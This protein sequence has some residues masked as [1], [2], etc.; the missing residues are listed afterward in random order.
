MKQLGLFANTAPEPPP[1]VEADRRLVERLPASILL[2]PSSW[3]F[4]DWEGI[5]YPTGMSREDLIERGLERIARYPLFRTVGIDRSHYAPLDEAT[6]QRY[7]SEL[8]AG[9]PCVIK[10]W[11]AITTLIDTR[12]HGQNPAF[13]DT[14]ACEKNVLLPLSRFFYEHTGPLVF[15]FTPIPAR[16]LPSQ[17]AFA[18]RLDRFFGALPTAFRYAVEI[19]NRELLGPAYFAALARHGVGHVLNLWERMPTIGQQL[20]LPGVLTAPFVV[21]RLSITPDNRYEEQKKRFMPFNRLSV[22]DEGMRA[23]VAALASAAL[24]LH[25][26]LFI[27]VNNKVEGC[28]PLTIRALIERIVEGLRDERKALP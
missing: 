20:A 12:T 19:R 9:F 6:L 4:A 26:T 3:T 27:T 11:N 21:A 13:L 1:H 16:N 8:P 5:V 25:K 15:Q 2:G 7:A 23:D 17:D 10:A 24:A 28:S 22:I 18:E 14:A